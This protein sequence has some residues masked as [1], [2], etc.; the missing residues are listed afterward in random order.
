MTNVSDAR[1]HSAPAGYRYMY[2][3]ELERNENIK[4]SM[5]GNLVAQNNT[6]LVGLV[7]GYTDGVSI[8]PQCGNSSSAQDFSFFMIIDECYPLPE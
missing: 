1:D 8:F 4:K 7:N 5:L 3:D 2:Y 6:D